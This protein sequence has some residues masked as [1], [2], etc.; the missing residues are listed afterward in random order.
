MPTIGDVTLTVDPPA[1]LVGVVIARECRPDARG[2]ALNAAIHQA[3]TEA[4]VRSDTEAVVGSVRDLLRY[5]K[6]KPTGRGKP[7]SEYLLNAA[8]D[9]RFPRVGT[10]VDIN[11]LVS[12]QSLLPISLI[13]LDRAAP[14]PSS[15]SEFVV[16][17]GRAGESYVFNAS[18]QRI[19]L[20][21]LLLVARLPDDR[22]CA[23]PVKDSM[24][25]K[26]AEGS[27]NVMAVLYAPPGLRGRLADATSAFERALEQ[28]AGAASVATAVVDG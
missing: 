17:R 27:R 15:A 18:G 1:V 23:T 9:D 25:T 8:R 12:L 22:P 21:D 7:A 3:L 26:L 14:A 2:D 16:R 24:E 13:D 5:R 6:Y 4:R 20:E 19:E 11:N 28:W 10:L